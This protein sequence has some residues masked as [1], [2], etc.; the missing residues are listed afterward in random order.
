MRE[1]EPTRKDYDAYVQ[2]F[3]RTDY[4]YE[5]GKQSGIR[6]ESYLFEPMPTFEQYCRAF[7]M[8]RSFSRQFK[9]NRIVY[10]NEDQ[11]V[12]AMAEVEEKGKTLALN[13]FVVDRNCQ[14]REYGT[15][16]YEEIEQEARHRGFR[17]IKLYS[18]FAGS[19]MF[20]LKMGFVDTGIF[21]KKL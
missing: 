12:V 21:I 2:C 6:K 11:Q 19:I 5:V 16:F 20:W 15:K 8:N 10:E 7:E 18:N 14:F 4:S 3:H 13:E 17:E 9:K 1:L